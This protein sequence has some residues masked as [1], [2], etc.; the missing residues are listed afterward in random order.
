[1]TQSIYDNPDFFEGY[2]RLS[3]SVKGLAGH[4]SGRHGAAS[5]L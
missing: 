2:S 5:A 4:L 3:R 1:M